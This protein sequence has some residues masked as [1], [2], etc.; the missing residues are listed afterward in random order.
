MLM[1]PSV[2]IREAQPMIQAKD[3]L[4]SCPYCKSRKSSIDPI[5]IPQHFNR[6]WSWTRPKISTPQKWMNI[7]P[8]GKCYINDYQSKFLNPQWLW[9]KY[10][11]WSYIIPQYKYHIY[12]KKYGWLYL[13]QKNGY[14]LIYNYKTKEWDY[15]GNYSDES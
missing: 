12:T 3:L 1:M 9:I 2:T 11:G 5:P 4:C 10:L 8:Y 6:C 14:N 7:K 13:L 15:M